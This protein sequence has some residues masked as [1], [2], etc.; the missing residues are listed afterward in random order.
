MTFRRIYW[1]VGVEYR[2]TTEQLKII[3]DGIMKYI[4]ESGDFQPNDQVNTIVRI[5]S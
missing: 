3:R 2:T 5:D 1:K 4:E